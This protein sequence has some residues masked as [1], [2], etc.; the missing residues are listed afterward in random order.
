M[1]EFRPFGIWGPLNIRRAESGEKIF[2]QSKQNSAR[3]VPPTRRNFVTNDGKDS[4]DSQCDEFLEVPIYNLQHFTAFVKG[5]W[6]NRKKFRQIAVR[7]EICGEIVLKK[8]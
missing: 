4:A 1:M 6:D 5:V 7:R 3:V 2:R 8:S